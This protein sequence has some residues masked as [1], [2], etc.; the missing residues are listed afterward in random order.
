MRKAVTHQTQAFKLFPMLSWLSW[1]S[2]LSL[3]IAVGWSERNEGDKDSF[4]PANIHEY[5]DFNHVFVQLSPICRGLA[6]IS[7]GLTPGFFNASMHRVLQGSQIL[8][9]ILR[10]LV[11]VESWQFNTTACPP[12]PGQS[13]FIFMLSPWNRWNII[14]LATCNKTRPLRV[15]DVPDLAVSCLRKSHRQ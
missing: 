11:V 10:R 15:K 6:P 9:S 8:G 7:V 12:L 1:C 14:L 3:G 5:C 13:I 2:W 4:L